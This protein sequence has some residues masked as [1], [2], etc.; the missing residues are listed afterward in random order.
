MHFPCS[1]LDPEMCQFETGKYY[2]FR[3]E[4]EPFQ[5]IKWYHFKRENRSYGDMPE[6]VHV[7]R[8]IVWGPANGLNPR[9]NSFGPP[10]NDPILTGKWSYGDTENRSI[11][12]RGICPF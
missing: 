4:M 9:E 11:L 6:M 2:K 1:I 10:E 7:D 12:D 8:G 3:P 5:T